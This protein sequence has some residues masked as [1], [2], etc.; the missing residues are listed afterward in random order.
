MSK[1]PIGIAV[2]HGGFRLKQFVIGGVQEA[3]LRV[4]DLGTFS[5]E[6]V[7]Y[8]DLAENLVAAIIGGKVQQGILVCGTGIGVSIAANRHR[9]IRAALCYDKETAERARQHNN[10][11]VLC[12]GGRKTNGHLAQEMVGIFLQTKFQGGRHT[13]R[14]KKLDRSFDCT[15]PVEELYDKDD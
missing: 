3:G 15:M 6:P 8:P 12:L 14:I 10:A 2:D 9:S 4:L 1:S 7:D 13:R 11:N 5:E